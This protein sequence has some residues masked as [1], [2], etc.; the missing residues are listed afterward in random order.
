MHSPYGWLKH[1][2]I[3][4][5]WHRR[6]SSHCCNHRSKMPTNYR[7]ENG[8]TLFSSKYDC[9][10]L[11]E[12]RKKNGL[13]GSGNG[14]QT[15]LSTRQKIGKINTNIFTLSDFSAIFVIMYRHTFFYAIQSFLDVFMN[16]S[17]CICGWLFHTDSCSIQLRLWWW[18]VAIITTKTTTT[19]TE[20]PT[21]TERH[22]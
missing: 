8:L 9:L 4:E 15:M 13:K 1:K 22:F 5:H 20:M 12:E 7:Y 6:K 19:T 3:T 14:S 21:W 18:N 10:L 16:S 2:Q 11:T 17:Y